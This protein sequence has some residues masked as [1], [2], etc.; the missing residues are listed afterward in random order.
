MRVLD[1]IHMKGSD[2]P[3]VSDRGVAEG[4]ID[5]GDWE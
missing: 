5:W 1:L 3:L 2:H 4:L